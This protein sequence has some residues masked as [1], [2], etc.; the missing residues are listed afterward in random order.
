MMIAPAPRLRRN[1]KQRGQRAQGHMQQQEQSSQQQQDQIE[2]QINPVGWPEQR[3][4]ALVAVAGSESPEPD[5]LAA[6]DHVDRDLHEFQRR[7]ICRCDAQAARLCRARRER[8]GEQD[9]SDGSHGGFSTHAASGARGGGRTHMAV[10]PRDF[11]SLAYTGFATR[12][13]WG[14]CAGCG[15]R[16]RPTRA[17]SEVEGSLPDFLRR[18]F[19]SRPWPAP[20][21]VAEARERRN[22]ANRGGSKSAWR[23]GSESNRRT[24][25]C[26]PLHDH[27]ATWPC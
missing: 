2:R 25:L 15:E 11:K 12:A 19:S 26:R 22:Q 8:D 23:P 3:D 20:G 4:R 6:R 5:V 18:A 1:G 21:A 13:W 9:E 27:S 14:L 24:R 7:G 16:S 17:P 10:R